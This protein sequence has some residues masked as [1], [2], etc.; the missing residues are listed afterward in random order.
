MTIESFNFGVHDG[1]SVPGFS[2][3]NRH[4]VTMNVVAY[5]A[6]L[7]GLHMPDAKGRLA[8]IVLGFDRIDDYRTSDAYMGATCGRYGNRIRRGTFALEGGTVHV[9]C[10]EGA[11]HAHGGFHGFDRKVWGAQVDAPANRVVFTL[12]SPDGDEGYPGA[13][14]VSASY[15]LT[16]DNVIELVMRGQTDRTTVINLVHHTYW[17]LAGHDAGDIRAH[18]LRMPADFYTPIDDELVPTG[19][20]HSVTGT[21]FDFRQTKAIGQHLDA[22]PTANGGYDHN[23]C[24]NGRSGE[25]RLGAALA[26]PGSGRALEIFTTAPG[27]QF[28]TGG[29]LREVIGK[30]G[31]RYDQYAGLA[32]ETQCFPNAP[33]FGHFPSP[34]LVPGEVY[35]HR[36]DVRLHAG[37]RENS[38]KNL[39]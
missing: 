35:E 34:R 27:V 9:S 39:T 6:R 23:W 19:E 38:W 18:R 29:H 10:N 37:Q 1:V 11:N 31:R 15:R 24:L 7:T 33:N 25:M 17:N 5:G 2:V 30:G 16:D 20:V 8:D 26:D 13:V 32:L 4:D 28:Y 14:I 21:P 12:T 36:M 3:R 22:I